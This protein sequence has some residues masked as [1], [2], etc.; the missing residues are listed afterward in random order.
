MPASKGS[1]SEHP[2]EPMAST[3]SRASRELRDVARLIGALEDVVGDT[4][5]R[6]S[7]AADVDVRELQQL[8][9]IR[10]KIAGAAEFLSAL[11]DNMPRDWMID[12][13]G[14]ASVITPAELAARLGNGED[15][16]S[17]SVPAPSEL[18]EIFD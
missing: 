14:A 6:A 5:E 7:G 15:E 11:T 12:A 10:Q 17:W 16:D 3:L 1:P 4:I 2:L 8:D 9:H 18:F 13:R